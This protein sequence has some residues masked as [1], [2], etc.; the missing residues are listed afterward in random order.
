MR[1][2]V[3]LAIAVVLVAGSAVRADD[4]PEG[5]I[6]VQLKIDDGKIVV[7]ATIEN[8]PAEKAG[9]KTDDILIK[10]DDFEAKDNLHDTVQEIIKHKPGDK[11]KLTVKCGDKEMTIEV[12]VGKRSEIFK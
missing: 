3:T 10:V 12:V 6:G 1:T 8:A 5:S 7:V 4:M 9:I 11:I 2:F